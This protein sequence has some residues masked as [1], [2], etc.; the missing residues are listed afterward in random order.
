MGFEPTIPV[1]EWAKRDHASDGAAT[2]IGNEYSDV[3]EYLRA[4]L[5]VRNTYIYMSAFYKAEE[6]QGGKGRPPSGTT[7][8][9]NQI[10]TSTLALSKLRVPFTSFCEVV[11]FGHIL[12]RV[13]ILWHVDPLLGNGREISS[14]TTFVAK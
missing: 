4:S 13:N 12:L 14:S 5:A 10:L 11:R 9:N 7:Y 2:A 3:A 1:F 8:G 6:V